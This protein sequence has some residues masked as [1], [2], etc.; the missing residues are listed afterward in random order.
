MILSPGTR[1]GVYEILSPVGAG[2]MGEVYRAR[3]TRLKRDIAVKVLS[4]AWVNDAGRL[5]RFQ[6]EAELLA[7]LSHPN[8][9]AIH[10]LEES[11]DIKALLLEFVEGPTL[12]DLIGQGPM[13]V[14]AALS[15][16]RQIAEALDAAHERG[17]V[18]RDLKPANIKVREDGTVKVLDFGLA[19]ALEGEG[20][21]EM[22][23]STTVTNAPLTRTGVVMGT[24]AYMSPEQARGQTVDRRTDIW[25][26][27]CVFYEMLAG[28]AA[29]AGATPSDCIAA[30]LQREPDW[31]ALPAATPAALRTLLR[32]CLEKDRR[33]RLRDIGDA[34]IDLDVLA[35]KE[36][37]GA[38]SRPAASGPRTWMVVGVASVLVLASM[39]AVIGVRGLSS[40]GGVPSSGPATTP[41]NLARATADEGVTADPALSNDGALLAYASDRAGADNLNIW[42]QQ[43][44][45]STPLQLTRDPAD[46]REPSLSPDGSRLAFRSERDGGGIY[47]VPTLG[48]QTPRLLVSGGRRPRFSP[49]GRFVAYWTGSNVGFSSNTGEYR[50]FV[51][52]ADGGDGREISGFAGAR[53]PVWAPDGRSLLLLGSRNARPLAATYDWWRVPV[54]G[55]DAI[56]IRADALLS[57][58]G[59][60]FDAGDVHPDDWRG[61][62]VLFS[63][64]R[65]LWSMRLDPGTSTASNPERLTFGTN[66]DFQ[67]SST[68]SGLIAFAS[69][70]VSNGVWALPIDA[71]R[72]VVTGAPLRLTAGVGIEN[73]ASASRDGRLVAYRSLIPRPSILI[74]D[75]E[76]QNV[77]DIG[78]AGTAFGPAISPDGAHVAY[79]E[80]GGVRV[81]ASRGGTPRTLCQACSIGDWWP[82]SQAVVVVKGEDN[83]GR[84][85]T[86]GLAGGEAHDVVV[87]S[88]QTVNRPFPSPDGRWLAFRRTGIAGDTILIAP[89]SAEQPV[90]SG[91]WIQLVAAE[92]DARPS[93]WSPDGSLV[94][95]VSARDGTRC[96]YAQRIDR[97]SGAA[98]REPILV[99]HFHGG[100]NVYRTG[101]NV[102]ST[103]PAN[104]VTSGFFLY[105]LSDLT[106]NIWLMQPR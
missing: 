93:G 80:G 49:D 104:A 2:G 37:R 58:A 50:T 3:D 97:T 81:V 53:Y 18:H 43:T 101:L 79:E 54:E 27:G 40:G 52:P 100:R 98:V 8:I 91:A 14:E 11:T 12:A 83:A 64:G 60:T 75:I 73:R 99:R 51:I 86:I 30:I 66:N 26:F 35:R 31:S 6:R 19:K 85:T 72:G 21:A 70:S 96:L 44:A 24:A 56:P 20:S 48:G 92:P 63:D 78:A 28:R 42:V 1:L 39:A 5:L 4:A 106:A 102:L 95:F 47:I 94:Y 103:G 34:R 38:P 25:A 82:D 46:E 55:T 77:I 32:R 74:K 29:F 10:G 9:A 13:T 57:G 105:D 84:L 61:G 68:A 23:Q 88:D 33:Q 7:A 15:I 16:A 45:G 36:D 87:S 62:R 90:S 65:F 76:T 17:I 69:A 89:L 59:I 67:V 22:G 71:M 41:Q